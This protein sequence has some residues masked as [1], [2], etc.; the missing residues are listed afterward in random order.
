MPGVPD[1]YQGN[2]FWDFSMVD[3]DNRTPVD[4][5]ARQSALMALDGGTTP[6]SLLSQ[7]RDGRVK[8]AV[9]A[10]LLAVRTDKPT[11]FSLGDYHALVV[12]GKHA[13]H[14]L[15]FLRRNGSER[16]V[17]VVTLQA[18]ALLEGS[19]RPLVEPARWEDTEVVLPPGTASNAWFDVV[20]GQ[21]RKSALRRLKLCELL[22]ELPVAVLR[23]ASRG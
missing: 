6:A 9:I 10:S 18:A 23:D 15:A 16:M 19:D 14:V 11:L 1:V 20:T 21:R 7:W 2:E 12:E 17:V 3:P 13:G 5:G 8:Q 22:S 4:F